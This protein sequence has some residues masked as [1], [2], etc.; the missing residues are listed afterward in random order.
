MQEAGESHIIYR[1]LMFGVY[2]LFVPQALKNKL[3][4][5]EQMDIS[6]IDESIKFFKETTLHELLDDT[7]K[8]D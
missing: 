5:Y 4:K 8:P 6:A 3:N 2:D 1:E 7:E